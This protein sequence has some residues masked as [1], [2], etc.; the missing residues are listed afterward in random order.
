MAE[1]IKVFKENIPTMRFIGKKYDN[2]GHWGEWWQN[3]WFDLIENAMGGTDKILSAWE[4][5]GG[6]IG[7]ERRAEG[8][9]I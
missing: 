9:P 7:V 6:Y 8:Q 4:N 5:G 2:F 1:I 3:G